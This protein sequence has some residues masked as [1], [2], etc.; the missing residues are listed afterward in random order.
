MTTLQRAFACM[1]SILMALTPMVPAQAA[2]IGNQALLDNHHSEQ[3]RNSLQQL[4][5]QQAAREQLQ[6]MGVDASWAQERAAR[7]TDAELAR[8]NQ[9]IEQL[10]A[11][12]DVL[13]VILIIFI[14]FVI[15]DAIGATD[16][17]SFVHPIR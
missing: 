15:T 3:T 16:V 17:F 8:I 7:L 14:V 11:G 9:G 4:M 1:L 13:G 5:N 12:G 6:S 2:M 10:N